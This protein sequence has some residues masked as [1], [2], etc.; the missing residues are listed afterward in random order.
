MFVEVRRS[1]REL[2]LC[3]YGIELIP[4][5]ILDLSIS[6]DLAV[7]NEV[8]D[9]Y[10]WAESF[11]NLRDEFEEESGVHFELRDVW[12]ASTGPSPILGFFSNWEVES[13]TR[14]EMR[15]IKRLLRMLKYPKDY[16]LRWYP[17]VDET[18][19]TTPIDTTR[20]Y[21][22]H[23]VCSVE[24][25]VWMTSVFLGIAVHHF[26]I[27]LRLPLCPS[28]RGH[29]LAQAIYHII[30]SRMSQSYRARGFKYS[31]C[32]ARGACSV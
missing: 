23:Y 16:K 13:I 25:H 7:K 14:K 2:P 3:W 12:G 28:C 9:R 10:R 4:K 11:Y 31:E 29:P 6:L 18:V 30:L 32:L 1:V 17:D 24:D 19:S 22:D 20:S 8:T 27:A 26:V 5:N 21:S 15:Y